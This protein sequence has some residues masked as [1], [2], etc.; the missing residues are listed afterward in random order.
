[1]YYCV[2]YIHIILHYSYF[3]SACSN[4]TIFTLS[5][6]D[7]LPIYARL[8][9]SADAGAQ[10]HVVRWGA[11][12]EKLY[13]SWQLYGRQS[14]DLRALNAGTDYWVAVDSFNDSGVTSGVVVHLPSAGEDADADRPGRPR[15]L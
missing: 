4:Y 3:F 14:L 10:G 2:T 11:H 9:W 13:H 15:Q 5:L 7:A 12:P 8:E 6:H 1:L